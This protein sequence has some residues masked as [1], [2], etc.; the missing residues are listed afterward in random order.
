[1]ADALRSDH[2][3]LAPVLDLASE[4]GASS[5]LTCRPLSRHGFTLSKEISGMACASG[6]AGHLLGSQASAC[7]VSR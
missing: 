3:E 2:R 7:A 4:K 1:M 6:T 5:W